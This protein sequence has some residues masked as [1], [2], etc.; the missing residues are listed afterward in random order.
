M[1]IVPYIHVQIMII[2]VSLS[3]SSPRM[4]FPSNGYLNFP[5]PSL[6][7]AAELAF[8][9]LALLKV[10]LVLLPLPHVGAAGNY[11]AQIEDGQ[12]DGEVHG[13][14]HECQF[15]IPADHE[16]NESE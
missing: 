7:Q 14:E 9:L 3:L 4:I 12:V 13:G 15:E 8:R 10:L 1:A 16:D 11:A 2:T 5:L 6:V